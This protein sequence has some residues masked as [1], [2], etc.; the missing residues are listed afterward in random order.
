M[1]DRVLS[2]RRRPWGGWIAVG[3][4]V[5]LA[6]LAWL[7]YR[8]INEWQRSARLLAERRAESAVD[9]LVTAV[10]RD[11]RGVQTS[12]LSSL[13]FDE[14][15]PD[16]TLDLY[17]VGSAFARYPYPEAFFVS[18]GGARPESMMF[19]SRA[20]RPAPW[21]PRAGEKPRFPVVLGREPRVAEILL[22]RVARDAA[23]G[24]RYAAF[25]VK[26]Q[27]IECQ[28][29]ALLSYT[30]PVRQHLDAIV[31]FVVNL[32]WIRRNYFDELRAQV[33][34]IRGGDTGLVLTLLDGRGAPV[35]DGRPLA[36]D[37]P[38]RSRQFPVLFLDPGLVALNPPPDLKREVW[39]ARATVAGDPALVAA[40]LG[41]QRTLSL[42]AASA[43]LMVLGIALSVRAAR[44]NVRLAAMR[45]D[46]VS[47][48]THELKTPIATIRALSETL[49]SGRSSTAEMSRE[50]A[51]L[52]VEEAK[53]LT[54]LIDNLLAY[55]RI[56]DV[57]EAYAFEPVA[58]DTIAQQSLKEFS[59]Q[60]A[61]GGFS[62]NVDIPPDLPPVRADLPSMV[63]AVS[64]LLDNAI[65]YSNITR[66][67]TVAARSS[68]GAVVLEVADAGAGIPQS[69]IEH[70]TRKFFRGNG[71]ISGGSGLGLSIA[72][73]IVF[74]HAGSLS[75]RSEVG[76]GTTVGVTLPRA[77][78][79]HEET[80]THR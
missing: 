28:V 78:T 49:A 8:A 33:L 62:V 58:V 15:R 69:E 14:L 71:A 68:N 66:R 9:L 57:T 59:W 76:V 72:Q 61:A 40:R 16:L 32:D 36:A 65:R 19:Y 38:S 25:D 37:G 11:M 44:A 80:R 75:I 39:T 20:D 43:L 79:D 6:M 22:R 54:R 3:A 46:F 51:Q 45:S 47:A 7:G 64:N 10:T 35:V 41:A 5:S 34:R 63:L 17:D 73:R 48:V 31:G 24:R 53:R 42:A 27:D 52:A 30:D 13:R 55:A 77:T 21:L 67:L 2:L 29:V 70:V 18:R 23:E 1:I 26:L 12:V 74:D 56:T 4:C 50:Y 60:L